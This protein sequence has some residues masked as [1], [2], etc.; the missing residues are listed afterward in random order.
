MNDDVIMFNDLLHLTDEE[1]RRTKI[2]F[3]TDYKGYKPAEEFKK[4]PNKFNIEWLL[5][6]KKNEE[7]KDAEWL[8]KGEN[9]IGLAR[10]PIDNDL[11]VFTCIK[12]IDNLLERPEEDN[13]SEYY[14]GYEGKE[15]PKYRKFYGRTIVRYHKV[16]GEAQSIYHAEGLL[17]KL[18]VEEVLPPKLLNNDVSATVQAILSMTGLNWH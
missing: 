2:R 18:P 6:R 13:E 17:G 9:V 11:W 15:L 14:A 8:H 3:L 1:I 16:Q 10:L 12:R 4:D 5:A 7:G